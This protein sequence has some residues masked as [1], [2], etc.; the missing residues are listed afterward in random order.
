MKLFYAMVT[1]LIMGAVIGMGIFLA[2][3]K[4]SYW[5]L[6]ASFAAFVFAIGKI[7]CAHH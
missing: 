5:L 7:G 2:A 6:I 1:W 3:T 4:G